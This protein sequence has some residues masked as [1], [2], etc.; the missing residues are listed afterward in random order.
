MAEPEY[1]PAPFFSPGVILIAAM[2]G[3]VAV[4]ALSEAGIV[5]VMAVLVLL[6]IYFRFWPDTFLARRLDRWNTRHHIEV[7]S[8]SKND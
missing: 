2:V 7:W 8:N 5:N 6:K 3:I 1:R 4:M